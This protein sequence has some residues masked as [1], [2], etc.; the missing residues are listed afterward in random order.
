MQVPQLPADQKA[1]V[2]RQLATQASTRMWRQ[3][4]TQMRDDAPFFMHIG[5]LCVR[6]GLLQRVVR[7][8]SFRIMP[9]NGRRSVDPYESQGTLRKLLN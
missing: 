7:W 3:S 6:L 4:A 9:F 2:V 5:N 8:E 1:E